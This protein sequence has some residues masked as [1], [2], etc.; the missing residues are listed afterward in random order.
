MKSAIFKIDG[1]HCEGCARTVAAVISNQPGVQKAAVS[2][3]RREA[4]ILFDPQSVSEER[5]STSI[6]QAGY[7]VVGRS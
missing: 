2:F 3:E 5:L 4:R 1:M 7:A 6:R